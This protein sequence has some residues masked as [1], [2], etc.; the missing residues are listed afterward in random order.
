MW[1]DFLVTV[2]QEL[3]NPEICI[4]NR[5]LSEAKV[6]FVLKYASFQLTLVDELMDDIKAR[7]L[8]K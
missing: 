8:Y 1:N 7:T 6:G 2:L 4:E 5:L 3:E